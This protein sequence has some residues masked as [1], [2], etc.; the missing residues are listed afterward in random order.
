MTN[1][2]SQVILVFVPL[3]I[4]VHN[5]TIL[6]LDP[7]QFAAMIINQRPGLRV[8]ATA[9]T[10]KSIAIL[11]AGIPARD[12]KLG[13]L[14]IKRL[15]AQSRVSAEDAEIIPEAAPSAG[16]GKQRQEGH[17]S[18]QPHHGHEGAK[19][20]RSTGENRRVKE[21]FSIAE[22]KSRVDVDWKKYSGADGIPSW[23]AVWMLISRLCVADC[24]PGMILLSP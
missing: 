9:R 12:M 17:E 13:C 7:D 20:K 6:P 14:D 22:G 3:H 11:A 16:G 8:K 23:Q 19:R 18:Q 24:G 2:K 4:Q 1:P 15:E 21:T 5:H 10:E